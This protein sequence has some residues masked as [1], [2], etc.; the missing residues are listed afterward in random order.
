LAGLA[1]RA[2]PTISARRFHRAI[3]KCQRRCSR[4]K[5]EIEKWWPKSANVKAK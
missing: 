4:I 1:V 5:A 2:A 3:K